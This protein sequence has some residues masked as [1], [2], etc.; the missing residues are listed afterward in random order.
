MSTIEISNRA[1][2]DLRRMGPGPHRDQV[3]KGLQALTEGA[4]NLDIKPIDGHPPWLRL[5]LGDYRVLY[6]I[7][8]NGW[9]VERVVNR[10]DLKEAVATL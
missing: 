1:K 9:W 7:T 8:E 10:R 2:R 4:A 5:R 6:R 3:T